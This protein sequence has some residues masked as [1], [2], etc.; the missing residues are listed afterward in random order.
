MLS[1]Y[2]GSRQL[3]TRIMNR[4]RY[5][6]PDS[7]LYVDVMLTSTLVTR[8]QFISIPLR[9]KEEGRRSIV[10]LR[11]ARNRTYYT[12]FKTAKNGR[13]LKDLPKDL[14]SRNNSAQP[15]F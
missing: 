1:M 14:V 15:F 8:H 12:S 11:S 10:I 9:G 6:L 4:E 2:E 5:E 3:I 7:D 13:R